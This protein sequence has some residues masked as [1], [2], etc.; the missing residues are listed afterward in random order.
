MDFFEFNGK[1][2]VNIN[3]KDYFLLRGYGRSWKNFLFVQVSGATPLRKE[4]FTGYAL[5]TQPGRLTF[6]QV[7]SCP[8]RY[9]IGR[10]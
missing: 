1:P 9:M 7:R 10:V 4:D 8:Y 2:F 6:R 3:G 5:P